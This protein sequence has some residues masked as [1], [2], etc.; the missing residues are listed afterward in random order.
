MITYQSFA[1]PWQLLEKLM[2]RYNAPAH[3]TE[4]KRVPTQLRVAAVLEHWIQYHFVDLDT[5]EVNRLKEFIEVQLPKDGY[6]DLSRLLGVEL[7]RGLAVRAAKI[8]YIKTIPIT[9]MS[10]PDGQLSPAALF[11]ALNE[12]EIARQLTLIEFKI[13]EAVEPTELLNQSWN[14]NELKHRAPNILDMISRGNRL[15]LACLHDIVVGHS[16]RQV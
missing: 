6:G 13:F 15:S 14:K 9:D 7:H 12:S 11:L 2:Q 4:D 8:S 5:K 1:T 3:I 16:R 10:V